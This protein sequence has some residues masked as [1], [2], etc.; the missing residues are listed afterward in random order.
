MSLSPPFHP[1]LS[2]LLS[3]TW[4]PEPP[5][6]RTWK[7]GGRESVR[8][9]VELE[10]ERKKGPLKYDIQSRGIGEGGDPLFPGCVK[11]GD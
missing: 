11:L 5:S 2:Q 3:H 10:G 7:Q 1:L 8:D 6:L 9:R 4:T